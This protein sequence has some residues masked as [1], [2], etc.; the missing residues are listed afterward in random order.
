MTEKGDLIVDVYQL[1]ICV[2]EAYLEPSR[3]STMKL[4]FEIVN[5]F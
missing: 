3:T 4:F 5:G 2:T 1:E